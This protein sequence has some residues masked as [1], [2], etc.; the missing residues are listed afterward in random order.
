MLLP[1]ETAG[2]LLDDAGSSPK[3]LPASTTNFTAIKKGLG[4]KDGLVEQMEENEKASASE[5]TAV[6]SERERY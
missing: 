2:Q 6:T 5:T 1:V 3:T 4:D